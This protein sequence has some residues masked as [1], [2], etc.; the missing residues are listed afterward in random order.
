M[1]NDENY[2]WKKKAKEETSLNPN[3]A[4]KKRETTHITDDILTKH[5]NCQRQ[6]SWWIKHDNII[7]LAWVES[8]IL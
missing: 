1:L 4:F 3:D 2:G 6:K 5:E 7:I 8:L